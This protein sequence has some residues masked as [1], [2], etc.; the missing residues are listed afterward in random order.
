MNRN[1]RKDEIE[2]A[3][4]V[5]VAAGLRG[6]AQFGAA[7]GGAA[8]LAHHYWPA[9]RRQTLPFKAWLV[10]ISAIFG[11]VIYAENALQAHEREERL[12]ENSIRREAR[13]ALARRGLVATE[14]EI[15]KWKEERARAREA[16]PAEAE[17]EATRVQASASEQ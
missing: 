1:R 10:S 9:F 15:A 13:L 8:A 11:L 3:Y 14:T 6:A 4:E 16:A 7:G 5:Q 17:Q 12:R 2:K